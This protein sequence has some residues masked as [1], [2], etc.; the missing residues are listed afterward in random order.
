LILDRGLGV[1]GVIL[2]D[3]M[4]GDESNEKIECT[5]VNSNIL[6]EARGVVMFESEEEGEI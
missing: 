4:V 1:V 5:G 2:E 6:A 3:F